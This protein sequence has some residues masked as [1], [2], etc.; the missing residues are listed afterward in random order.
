MIDLKLYSFRP[1]APTCD[2]FGRGFV[3]GADDCSLCEYQT[4]LQWREC[5]WR[6]LSLIEERESVKGDKVQQRRFAPISQEAITDADYKEWLACCKPN[7]LGSSVIEH[8]IGNGLISTI[9]AVNQHLATLNER[10]MIYG[11]HQTDD[12]RYTIVN[13]FYMWSKQTKANY[14]FTGR[15]YYEVVG[16]YKT[17]REFYE[18]ELAMKAEA[19]HQKCPECGLKVR[20]GDMEQHLKGW[21][22]AK[23]AATKQKGKK[24]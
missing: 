16:L 13:Y 22:H 20:C 7:T 4:P 2:R 15:R 19:K 12:F 14:P 5:R 17:D 11:Y 24:Q 8:M 23:A 9:E 1:V 6:Q 10:S 18:R 3:F 21:H